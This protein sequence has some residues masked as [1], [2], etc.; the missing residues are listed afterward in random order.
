M[1]VIDEPRNPFLSIRFTTGWNEALA[2]GNLYSYAKVQE[3]AIRDDVPWKLSD[4]VV[5]G[6]IDLCIKWAL[7]DIGHKLRP[8][9]D[10]DGYDI[11]DLI[12]R[13]FESDDEAIFKYIDKFSYDSIR[14]LAGQNQSVAKNLM[15]LLLTSKGM[16]PVV[17]FDEEETR[18]VSCM[19][20]VKYQLDM[21]IKNV[22]EKLCTTPGSVKETLWHDYIYGSQQC[23]GIS[24]LRE[25]MLS[26]IREMF[27]DE[28][29]DIPYEMEFLMWRY[30]SK[31]LFAVSHEASDYE[32]DYFSERPKLKADIEAY[33]LE[34]LDRRMVDFAN[35]RL[36]AGENQRED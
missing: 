22:Q 31:I 35:R 8:L 27:R 21:I 10:E 15:V 5:D 19:E 14:D 2:R 12:D 29:A 6:F 1:F 11:I 20:L 25:D 16:Q 28:I 17:E 36:E 18:T 33:L 9:S 3:K 23:N 24:Q 13:S 26:I 34:S 32:E 4:D 7:D 30:V